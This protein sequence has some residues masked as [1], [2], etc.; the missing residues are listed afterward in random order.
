M[1]FGLSRG[2][3]EG[4]RAKPMGV[5]RTATCSLARVRLRVWVEFI[6]ASVRHDDISAQNATSV[7]VLKLPL[8]SPNLLQR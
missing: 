2:E 8:V 1:A 6:R 7:T 4:R 3:V 5:F